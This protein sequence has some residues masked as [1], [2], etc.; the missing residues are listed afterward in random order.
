MSK[1]HEP[2]KNAA[3]SLAGSTRDAA[4]G[5]AHSP[6]MVWPGSKLVLADAPTAPP[7]DADK[8]DSKD[9]ADK[10]T[11]RLIKLQER[12]YVDGR[13]AMLVIFQAMD[14][15]GKDSTTRR[16]F[17]GVNPQGVRVSSFKVPSS[18]EQRH[19][20][21]WRIHAE[22]PAR[23][24]IRIFNRSQYEN[25][26][27]ERVEEITPPERWQKRFDHINAFEKLLADE[28]TVVL[29]FFLHISKDEQKERL[30]DRLDD[31]EKHWKF[32]PSDLDTRAKWA[33][34]MEAYGEAISRCS[35]PYAP[36]FVVP[37]DKKWY[38]DMVVLRA[39][40][41]ALEALDLRYPPPA[42]GLDKI[43]IP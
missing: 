31:P 16:V 22:C 33:A 6:H 38:R 34:Y 37:A 35:T 41:E 20:H 42:D 5:N 36:W 4:A 27:V 12:L 19:D 43:T 28:G 11:E 1:K 13:Y 32:N 2:E 17:A 40:V 30:Q 23:G 15:G 9:A 18:L 3:E 10:L 25:V 39:I 21:L 24:M 29:K 14:A 8:S 7:D 26:V